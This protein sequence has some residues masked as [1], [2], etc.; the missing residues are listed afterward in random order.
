M[1]KIAEASLYSVAAGA[2]LFTGAV[3]WE[4]SDPQSVANFWTAE[5]EA[6]GIHHSQPQTQEFAVNLEHN[7]DYAVG[8]AIASGVIAA[9]ALAV[10]VRE[11]MQRR[12]QNA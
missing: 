9:A 1:G 11:T 10:A 8:G 3:A 6:L 5:N 4:A 7:H 12:G 2:L